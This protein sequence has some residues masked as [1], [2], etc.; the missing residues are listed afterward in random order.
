MRNK[1]LKTKLKARGNDLYS[2]YFFNNNEII[3][4][5]I[6]AIDSKKEI[7]ESICETIFSVS[8]S[9]KSKVYELVMYYP[10][11]LI[12][13][14]YI[15]DNVINE[16]YEKFGETIEL[17]KNNPK[18]TNAR[19]VLSNSARIRAKNQNLP[20]TLISE[21]IIL[22][23]NCKILKTPLEYD[24]N[25]MGKYSP[26]LDKIIPGLG[27][28]KDNIQLISVLANN[29]KSNATKDEIIQFS[30]SMLEFY[31]VKS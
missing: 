3:L 18:N 27:Y 8:P 12:S 30:K 19:G 23:K 28:T 22:T 31:N 15:D 14:K 7:D 10:R 17:M 13:I 5:I 6:N 2:K 24:R 25:I 26:S 4:E 11:T 1:N 29:M 16:L 9:N 21:D 20:Y